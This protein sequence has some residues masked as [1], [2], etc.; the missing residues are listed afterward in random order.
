MVLCEIV[1]GEEA[2]TVVSSKLFAF[3]A[4][5]T[6]LLLLALAIFVLFYK[7]KS[8]LCRLWVVMSLLIAFWSFGFYEVSVAKHAA[9]ALFWSRFLNLA[10]IFIPPLYLHF[11]LALVNKEK[12]KKKVLSIAYLAAMVL[13]LFGFSPYFI[14][15]VTTA[16]GFFP[17]VIVPGPAYYAFIAYFFGVGLYV[18]WELLVTYRASRGYMRNQLKYV[19]LASFLALLGAVGSF[20]LLFFPAFPSGTFF[21]AWYCILI[22]FAA[23]K[24]R[25][26]NFDLAMRTSLAYS[27]IVGMLAIFFIL[28]FLLI[29]ERFGI[30]LKVPTMMATVVAA[31]IVAVAFQPLKEKTY[32][33]VEKYLL[34][35]KY[36]YQ[37][38]L[39]DYTAAVASILDL[40]QLVNLVVDR[41][42]H[43]MPI[44]SSSLWLLDEETGHYKCKKVAKIG[45]T[46]E[47]KATLSPESALTN[48]LRQRGKP[49]IKDE[50][51][52][53]VAHHEIDQ[54]HKDFD[55]LDAHLV[56]PLRF[57]NEMIGI[58]CLGEKTSGD[59]Y[60]DEDIRLLTTLS[61][62]TAVALANSFLY[63]R[64]MRMKDHNDNILRYMDSGVVTID[65]S[66]KITAFNRRASEITEIPES[67]ALNRSVYVLPRELAE[68]LSHTLKHGAIFSDYEISITENGKVIPLG[69]STS[70]LKG[71]SGVITG[72]LAVFA[73]LSQIKKLEMEVRRRER[74]ASLG[75]LAA[76]MAH[77]IKNPLVAIKTFTQLMPEKFDDEEFKSKF[78]VLV[79]QEVDRIDRL[80][81]QLLDFA[82]PNVPELQPVNL[83]EVI[84]ETLMLLDSEMS[85]KNIEVTK[86][87]LNAQPRVAG[88]PERLKQVFLNFFLNSL[89]SMGASG[90]L[91]VTLRH[92]PDEKSTVEVKITDTGKGIPQD[93]LPRIFDPFFT[94][95]EQ[96]SGLGLAVSHKILE[97]HGAEVEVTSAVDQGTTFVIRFPVLDYKFEETV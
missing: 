85:G 8:H 84:D 20:A 81:E 3:S 22:L 38:V 12:E 56:L 79:G 97:D 88:D 62:Q 70:L 5:L 45:G 72:V 43:A 41:V 35:D 30:I 14:K 90:R 36:D 80:V 26:M 32:S 86:D 11:I 58:W 48:H 7:R 6:T 31:L 53:L 68:V 50:L 24:H 77:E 74:L 9:I 39:R 87:Y 91:S 75:T 82:R 89:E 15:D 29:T 59:I 46:S 44:D 51:H 73:D 94:T 67:E 52:R 96:G 27:I 21:L 25:L 17:H 57:H 19:F 16:L 13:F 93:I 71:Q 78:T 23:L 4:L 69:V 61:H 63:D 10:A 92:L 33:L 18:H 1:W 42:V 76:G 60:S 95:K 55:I 83:G 37:V 2:R 40:Q 28:F 65:K 54:M 47:I 66:M 64:I 34:K 49:L